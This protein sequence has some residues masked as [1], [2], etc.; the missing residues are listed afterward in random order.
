MVLEERGKR[1]RK[2]ERDAHRKKMHEYKSNIWDRSIE[3]HR[4]RE[5]SKECMENIIKERML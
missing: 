4:D 3:K 1:K 2:L 5:R